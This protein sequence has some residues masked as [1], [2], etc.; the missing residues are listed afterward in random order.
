MRSASPVPA[1]NT[2]RPLAQSL[3]FPGEARPAHRPTNGQQFFAA[4]A[5]AMRRI[6]IE[7]ARRKQSSKHGGH[8]ARQDIDAVD[9]AAAESSEEVL[10]LDEAMQKLAGHDKHLPQ[11]SVSL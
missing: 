7:T 5:E 11:L 6:L 8:L 4:A 9:L 2:T 10:A 3:A 1:I